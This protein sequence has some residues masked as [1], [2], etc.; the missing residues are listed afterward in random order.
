MTDTRYIVVAAL[1][2]WLHCQVT[3]CRAGKTGSSGGTA[4]GLGYCG[5]YPCGGI[6]LRQDE[7]DVLLA[8]VKGS[9]LEAAVV[10]LVPQGEERRQGGRCETGCDV[11][12]S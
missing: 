7:E 2:L 12:A 10:Q 6:E 8:G 11:S 1:P 9:V 3:A 5:T 4:E